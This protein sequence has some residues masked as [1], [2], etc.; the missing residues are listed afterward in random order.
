MKVFKAEL[1]LNEQPW[2]CPTC[3]SDI[4]ELFRADVL[5][6]IESGDKQSEIFCDQCR[7]TLLVDTNGCEDNFANII[8]Q[9]E[10]DADVDV[11]Y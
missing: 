10:T 3:G 1:V 11:L 8:E 2:L 9:D 6:K 7:T 4:D 5:K